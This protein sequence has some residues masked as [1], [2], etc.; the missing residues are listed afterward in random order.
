M[1]IRVLI[2][3]LY[4][5]KKLFFTAVLALFA[6]STVMAEEVAKKPSFKGFETNGFW[7]NWEISLGAG[8]NYT[9]W[10]G[11]GFDQEAV[12][13]LGWLVE[14]SV[15]KWFTPVVGARVQLIGGRLN[16]SDDNGVKSNWIMPHA[17]ALVNISNWIGGYRA[18]RVYYA[19]LFA[20]FG[21][22]I[23]DV[24]H[25]AGT[26]FAFDAGLINTFRVCKA[27]DINLE[28]KGILNAGNNMPRAL[29]G[30]CGKYGQIYAATVGVAYRFNQRTW[31][32]SKDY[33]AADLKVYQ[34]AAAKAKAEAEAAAKENARLDAAL[35]NAN[36]D[37]AA[38]QQALAAAKAA[39]KPAH[40]GLSSAVVI[41]TIGK[42]T[43]TPQEKTRLDLIAYQ[44]K[45]GDKEHVYTIVGT[46]DSQTGTPALNQRLS[47]ARAKNVYD[48]LV[49]QGVNPD[50]LT[51]EGKGGV[52]HSVTGKPAAN[53]AATIK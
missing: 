40:T 47:E 26:G 36:A 49:K 3:K 30:Y 5:M 12:G 11:V 50:Q 31:T 35:K 32:R 33:T 46:A 41:Y 16:A 28:L 9:A 34:D 38:A 15:S 29:A 43:L 48:Y 22:S 20:G 14:G 8:A 17:D 1:D 2:N 44:I 18:D 39:Q 10:N 37:V 52:E 7:D 23:V 6:A 53:R 42:S 25:N 13:D 51:Y 19:T 21:T 45:N 4:T 24:K 27:L